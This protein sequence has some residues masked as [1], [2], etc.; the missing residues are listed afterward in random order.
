[1]YEEDVAKWVRPD[2]DSIRRS[3]QLSSVRLEGLRELTEQTVF[4]LPP[5]LME[6]EGQTRALVHFGG[7]V[8]NVG[9][10]GREAKRLGDLLGPNVKEVIKRA[11]QEMEELVQG[12]TER[13]LV[14]DR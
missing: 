8:D 5:A 4:L 1:M 2:P 14:G 9:D 10:L 12:W 7:V 3:L 13:N 6:A 11:E